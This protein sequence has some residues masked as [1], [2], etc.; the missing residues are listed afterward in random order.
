MRLRCQRRG[1]RGTTRQPS[2]G[3]EHAAHPASTGL[4]GW[5]L[6]LVSSG[7]VGGRALLVSD[8]LFPVS[9][10]PR[11]TRTRS[12]EVKLLLARSRGPSRVV[13]FYSDRAGTSHTRAKATPSVM[14]RPCTIC[15]STAS[16]ERAA[17]TDSANAWSASCS[18]GTKRLGSVGGQI[19]LRTMS[20][21]G[22][23]VLPRTRH[24]ATRA[25]RSGAL[26]RRLQSTGGG[27]GRTFS[28]SAF[29]SEAER[30]T[31]GAVAVE[32]RVFQRCDVQ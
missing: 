22:R 30:R 18:I 14:P 12:P 4:S 27:A 13:G 1:Q 29:A 17:A 19:R 24:V 6:I 21:A 25:R 11:Q 16:G 15:F 31:S 3:L 20:T 8:G 23:S 5:G 9:A 28:A 7:D 2:S 32:P 26:A 10:G